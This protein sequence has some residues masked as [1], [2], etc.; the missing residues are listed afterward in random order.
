M[1]VPRF[2]VNDMYYRIKLVDDKPVISHF[3]LGRPAGVVIKPSLR[4]F[5]S[6]QVRGDLIPEVA[7]LALERG[8]I[9]EV[10]EDEVNS[11]RKSLNLRWEAL[12]ARKEL[13]EIAIEEEALM[14][15]AAGII[16][17]VID[18]SDVD[19]VDADDADEED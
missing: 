9:E 18:G 15:E 17:E 14:K 7:A 12:Q 6:N 5:S 4:I 16:A 2:G 11:L 3:S 1:P 10:P 13:A 8:Y 19:E